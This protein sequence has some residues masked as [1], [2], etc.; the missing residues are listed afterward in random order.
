MLLASGIVSCHLILPLVTSPHFSPSTHTHTLPP[1]PHPP[2]LASTPS[3]SPRAH[4]S[5]A[6]TSPPPPP[7]KQTRIAL[8]RRLKVLGHI[9][10]TLPWTEADINRQQRDI[11][12]WNASKNK[13]FGRF[14][15][16]SFNNPKTHSK[17]HCGKW[18]RGRV[19]N[20]WFC[21]NYCCICVIIIDSI[22]MEG[23]VA[24]SSTPVWRHAWRE[25]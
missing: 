6:H 17:C 14:S 1:F 10:R 15:K 2:S 7:G 24:H 3:Y 19:Y 23:T 9:R 4:L 12:K 21:M 13:V 11:R 8:V 18:L 22:R 16:C 20:Y 5:L 25:Q